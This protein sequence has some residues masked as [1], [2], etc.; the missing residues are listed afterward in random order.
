MA[1]L[2]AQ[3]DSAKANVE[4]PTDDVDNASAAHLEV[5]EHL[6]K[7]EQFKNA[8]INTIL[9]G[10]YARHTSIRRVKDVDVFSKMAEIDPNLSAE[11]LLGDFYEALLDE[12]DENRVGLQDRSVKIDFPDFGLA[13]DAVPARPDGDSWQIPDRSDGE[14]DWERTNPEELG[15][16]TT[17]MNTRHDGIYVPVVKLVRQTRRANLGDH[18]GGLFFELLTY[19]AFDE[20]VSGENI[21]TAYCQAL[22]SLAT[23]L[24]DVIAGTQLDDPTIEDQVIRVRATEAEMASAAS[25]FVSIADKGE[26]ALAEPNRCKAAKMFRDILGKNSD[27]EW[28]FPMPADCNDDGTARAVGGA[29]AGRKTVPAGDRRFA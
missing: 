22:R 21:P 26:A 19:Y 5:R 27:D 13:V 20:D 23:Q 2:V 15:A 25:T 16:L 3:F 14:N 1:E 10:S 6:E 28:V 9:I 7:V 17:A 24:A 8:E 4:P 29:V 11:D 12:F 18:P